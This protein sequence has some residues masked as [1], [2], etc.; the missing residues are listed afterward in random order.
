M[1]NNLLSIV[2]FLPALAA[3]IL[4]VFLRGEDE[5]AQ[6]N[7]KWVAVAGTV[8]AF[9]ASLF[10]YS[11]FDPSNTGFQMVDEAEWLLGLSYRVGVD[12][13][14]VLFV[15]LTTFMMPLVIAASWDVNTRVKEYM[16]AFLLLETLMIG[17]F[18]SLDLILFYL[19]FEASLIPMFLII[20]IWGGA[21][22]I[23]ASF[24][25]F[26]YTF[27]GSVLMLVAMVAMF[28]DAGTT[29]IGGCD[30][31]LLTHTFGSE[32]FSVLGIHVVG[33]MQT[34]MFLAFFA[35]FA[36]KMPMWPVHTWLP[37]AHV[38]APT[39]GSVVLAAILL[40][41]GGYGFLRFSLPMFPVGSEVVGPLILWMSAIAIVYTS[42]VALVQE[43]MKKLIAYS[44][45]A[46]MGFVTMGIFSTN[47]Q[48]LDGAIFQM[49]SHGFISGALFL[50]VGVI[51]DRMHTREIDAYG[52]LVNRMP[53]YALLFMLFTMANVGLPGTS[54]FV[55]EFLTLMGVFQVNTWV[56]AVATTGVIFSAAYALWLYRRV[57]M[58]DLIKGSLKAITD[59]TS[60]EKWIFAPLVVMTLLLG[61]YPA[62]ILDVIGPSVTA[63]IEQYDTAVAA[64]EV[65]SDTAEAHN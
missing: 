26:L 37:D 62:L 29:C 15:M 59:M 13:I 43:D 4:M 31:S 51:Y 21:N 63:L 39:A 36:V 19:F 35:S 64:T 40:K 16:V 60:R 46:H 42:L 11:Q 7:A 50:S 3:V 34:L 28:A 54:G 55:G 53:V 2:T 1:E 14:S 49:I 47:Q 65:V 30:V 58:G 61:I 32:S 33:G 5:A 8:A 18:V 41:M 52:G 17:V 24:K 10:M 44:S 45:V 57:V 56:A 6:R 27:F 23:Y 12:G 20:G 9:V 22:R 38:Q 25:F 48:G